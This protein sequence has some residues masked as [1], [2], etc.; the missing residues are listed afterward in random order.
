MLDQDVA[1]TS[2]KPQKTT[3]SYDV[4]PHHLW[5]NFQP[6]PLKDPTYGHSLLGFSWIPQHGS[7]F[8]WTNDLKSIRYQISLSWV[9]ENTHFIVFQQL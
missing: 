2:P 1:W 6:K 5:E 7:H 8:S 4:P 3:Q 9:I